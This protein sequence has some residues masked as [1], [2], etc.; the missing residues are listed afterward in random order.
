MAG[1]VSRTCRRRSDYRRDCWAPRARH[2]GLPPATSCPR[3]A[4]TLVSPCQR[5]CLVLTRFALVKVAGTTHPGTAE[6]YPHYYHHPDERYPVNQAPG[7]LLSGATTVGL[8]GS[9][10]LESQSVLVGSSVG[11]LLRRIFRKRLSYLA[12]PE[13]R[14]L[15]LVCGAAA[16]HR[17]RVLIASPRSFLRT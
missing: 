5:W 13:G 11:I 3:I 14:N 2:R 7:R 1:A 9:Q 6:L 17:N 4:G 8:G 16:R 12:R 10:G 15:L